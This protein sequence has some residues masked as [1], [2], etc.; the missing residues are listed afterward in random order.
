MELS[1]RN[2]LGHAAVMLAA[3]CSG[4]FSTA[5]G[6]SSG[7]RSSDEV[8]SV[9]VD[10]TRC[11]GCRACVRGCVEANALPVTDESA[12]ISLSHAQVLA[13]HLW[14]AVN[15]HSGKNL[16]GV[17]VTRTVKKQCMHCLEPAC[18]S[19]CPVAA[20][21]RTEDGPVIYR[22]NRCIG[23]RY[24]MVACPFDIPKFQWESGLTP[25]IGKCQFCFYNRQMRGEFPACVSACPT[26]A[27]KFGWRKDMLFEAR[28]RLHARPEKY[29]NHIF[30]EKEAGGTS[31]LYLSDVAFE[32]AGLR[33]NLPDK[34]LP[35]LT[36]IVLS[37][38]PGVVLT[39]GAV[40]SGLS[41]LLKREE[42]EAR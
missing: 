7:K 20:L 31:W 33:K 8:P 2:F 1:R 27:L 3:L 14:T 26:G 19:A 38:I 24:C 16:K 28:A 32:D 11:I 18:A 36:W 40:L 17:P 9:L 29:V 12:D 35:E 5:R 22:A 6:E 10:L 23:C 30:G 15:A 41:F 4:N 34:P 13:S 42:D 37:K 39:L 21:Y 25:V